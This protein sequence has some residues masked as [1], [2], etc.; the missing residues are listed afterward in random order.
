MA[1][2]SPRLS[3]LSDAGAHGITVIRPIE[4]A[5][6]CTIRAL[7]LRPHWTPERC[8]WPLDDDPLTIHLGGF[9]RE[10]LACVGS[11]VPD[12]HPQLQGELGAAPDTMAKLRGMATVEEHR[13]HGIGSLLLLAGMEALRG[14]GVQVL[15]CNAR[16]TAVRFY[17][18][19]GLVTWGEEFENSPVG[20][21]IVMWR[22][23]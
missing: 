11:F 14:R 22:R 18:R 23:L 6:A 2:E 4:A 10:Q 19:H 5:Q 21:H 1:G 7:V 17:E 13:G 9:V 15:W 20:P 3:Q 16:I 12:P 8:S